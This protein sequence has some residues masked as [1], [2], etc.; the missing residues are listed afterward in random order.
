MPNENLNNTP[1]WK[2]KLDS[3]DSL[4][5]EDMPDK[6]ALWEK[7]HGQLG[8]KRRRKQSAWYWVAASLVAFGL[9]I[10]LFYSN[11]NDQQLINSAT[12]KNQEL[13]KTPS[14]KVEKK[15]LPP[16]IN[17]VV[18]KNEKKSPS[19]SRQAGIN[20]VDGDKEKKIRLTYAASSKALIPEMQSNFITPIDTLSSLATIQ[21]EKK[22]LRVVH[23][24]E[25]GDPVATLPE[26]VK[27][28]DKHT[29][30]FKIA[31]QEI[32]INPTTASNTNSFTI[33]KIKPSQN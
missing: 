19:I 33:L 18:V 20:I 27:N 22:K 7:L 30:Q 9:I 29:F 14:N 5:G 3:L 28:S 26:V 13:V 21:P 1:I 17:S 23:I 16:A 25:L 32:Y 2:L 11:S 8:G 10:S 12:N 15:D 4:P 6:N 24:N 31:S